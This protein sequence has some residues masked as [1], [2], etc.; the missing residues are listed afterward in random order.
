MPFS[1]IH[2]FDVLLVLLPL[3]ACLGLFNGLRSGEIAVHFAPSVLLGY[4]ADQI[5]SIG[6][7]RRYALTAPPCR[8]ALSVQWL[9]YWP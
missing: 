7:Y 8:L 9:A 6:D 2:S 5:L 3:W 1:A 4:F